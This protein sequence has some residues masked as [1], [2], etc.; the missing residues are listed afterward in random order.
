MPNLTREKETYRQLR[1]MDRNYVSVVYK[2]DGPI[3]VL[4]TSQQVYT[5]FIL[6]KYQWQRPG[7]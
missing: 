4:D 3:S 2:E 7:S 1:R 5:E 6:T